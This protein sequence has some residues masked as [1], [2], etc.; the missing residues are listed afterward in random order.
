M[1]FYLFHKNYQQTK[2]AIF[3]APHLG[4]AVSTFNVCAFLCFLS[5]QRVRK[6]LLEK[7]LNL[8]QN[9]T[10]LIFIASSP[11]LYPALRHPNPKNL[12][13][14][15]FP[16]SY[17]V[18]VRFVVHAASRGRFDSHISRISGSSTQTRSFSRTC[19]NT[20]R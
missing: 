4:Y 18:L 14:I 12:N 6:R 10:F 19:Q 13:F 17:I 2:I 9:C 3:T 11:M 5:F 1:T 15:K 20:T 16:P 7:K 8:F